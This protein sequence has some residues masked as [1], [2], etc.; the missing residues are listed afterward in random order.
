MKRPALDSPSFNVA[1]ESLCGRF[2]TSRN[3]HSG[4]QK[5]HFPPTERPKSIHISATVQTIWTKR[6]AY[7]SSNTNVAN[8]PTSNRIQHTSGTDHLGLSENSTTLRPGGRM[9]FEISPTTPIIDFFSEALRPSRDDKHCSLGATDRT[10]LS[11]KRSRPRRTTSGQRVPENYYGNKK[12]C[13][14]REA[15]NTNDY[16]RF[17]T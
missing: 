17:F 8:E 14:R 10:G 6:Q 12:D 5:S 3:G 2:R 15:H 13:E 11:T 1:F 4:L 7:D 9:L 16:K